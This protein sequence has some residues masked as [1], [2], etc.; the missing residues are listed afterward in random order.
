MSYWKAPTVEAKK[1]VKA[2]QKLIT[3]KIFGAEVKNGESR[4]SK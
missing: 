3:N 1:A 2:P 4:N